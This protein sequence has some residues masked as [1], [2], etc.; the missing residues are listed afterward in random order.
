M[1]DWLH[2]LYPE[3]AD[4]VGEK[5]CDVTP[6]VSLEEFLEGRANEEAYSVFF[7]IFAPVL[8]KKSVWMENL[9]TNKPE[10]QMLTISSEAFGL[11][12]L[13]NSWDRWVDQY[14]LSGGLVA[15]Q[16]NCNLKAIN[17]QIFPVYT[18]GGLP[19]EK[20]ITSDDDQKV[21]IYSIQKGWNT[22]GIKRF[23]ELYDH[24]A[25]DRKDH[26]DF[27]PNWRRKKMAK[28]AKPASKKKPASKSASNEGFARFSL[29]D[30][31]SDGNEDTPNKEKVRRMKKK[32]EQEERAEQE[33]AKNKSQ[34]KDD[35][36]DEDDDEDEEQ[37]L[38]VTEDGGDGTEKVDDDDK[39]DELS[40]DEEE[41][42]RKETTD[43]KT[44]SRK[45]AVKPPSQKRNAKTSNGSSEKVVTAK[46]HASKTRGVSTTIASTLVSKKST[47]SA[48]RK[49]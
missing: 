9:A 29:W 30:N 11:L 38:P 20:E 15:I 24:V 25:R 40:E 35:K 47:R 1:K 36:T 12:L 14:N 46:R 37:P 5:Q 23:N 7:D 4:T 48:R 3:D 6:Q 26:P 16:K 44:P 22:K 31:E 43:A 28:K 39:I 41:E 10:K 32:A 21:N 34:A 13:E 18:R 33:R 49:K 17:S 2:E 27:F 19:T 8:E 42:A 45:K